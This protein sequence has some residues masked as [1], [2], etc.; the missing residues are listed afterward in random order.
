MNH[1]ITETLVIVSVLLTIFSSTIRFSRFSEV[2]RKER[3]KEMKIIYSISI[4][5]LLI[6]IVGLILSIN[7]YI[8]Q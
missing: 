5:V 4:A 3:K 7:S 1:I 8:S 2:E 6:N